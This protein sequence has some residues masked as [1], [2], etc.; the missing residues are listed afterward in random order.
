[1]D[2]FTNNIKL[3]LFPSSLIDNITV[4]KT[5]RPDLPGDWAGAY[6]SIDTKEY[7]DSLSVYVET[8][9]GYNNQTTFKDMVSSQRSSTDW[10]GYDNGFRN[11]DQNN[12]V[13]FNEKPTTYQEFVA[14][15]LGDYLRSIGVT[16]NTPWT[17]EYTK[18]GLVKFGLLGNA[19]IND[20]VAFQKAFDK[21][22]SLEYKGQ[23]F[24]KI[25]ADAVK[26][27]KTFPDTWNTTTRKAPLN[28]SQSFSIGNQTKLFGKPLGYLLGIRYSSAI[29]YDPNSSKNKISASSTDSSGHW[30]NYDF[31]TYQ[32][33]SKET[34]G[35]SGLINLA[36]KYNSNNSTSLMFMP[37]VIGVNSVRDGYYFRPGDDGEENIIKYLFYESRKQ[38][39]YQLK[40]EHYIPGPKI[41]IDFNASYTDGTSNAPDSK[42]VRYQIPR[43]IQYT[44]E[45]RFIVGN[46]GAG[47]YFR[48]LTD[49]IF[50]SRLSA[51]MPIGSDPTL[52]RK[53]KIGGAYQKENRQNDHYFY[54]LSPG[55]G[56][57]QIAAADT[58]AAPYGLDRFNIVTIVDPNNRPNQIRSVQEY[59]NLYDV[60]SNHIFGRSSIKAGYIMIDYSIIPALR[61]SGGLRAEQASMFT[62]CNMFNLNN[63]PANDDRR[64]FN[65]GENIGD[66]IVNPGVLNKVSYLP[67]ANLIV[68]L[69][70]DELAPMNVRLNFSQTVVRPSLQELTDNAFYDYELNAIVRG[71]SNLKM[72]QINNYDLRFEKYF[73][74]GDNIL[75]SIFYKDFRNHI[76]LLNNGS[77]FFWLNNE[78][79]TWLRGVEIEG[80]KAITAY[81]EFKAN[82]T[83]VN[84]LSK[85]TGVY[86][87]SLGHTIIPKQGSNPMFGQAPY[88]INSMLNYYSKKLG[89]IASLNYNV[90]GPRLVFLSDNK[91]IPDVYE[92]PRN[93][94]DFKISKSIGRY[95]SASL[96]FLDILNTP[97]VRAYKEGSGYPLDYDRYKYGTNYVV[98]LSYKF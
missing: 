39:V 3:D 77:S 49:N 54:Q 28:Y 12:F 8:S 70:H 43:L 7:P 65:P 46:T 27:A 15:G 17:D 2:P 41:K 64:Q 91:T 92:L 76:E 63:I 36:Y 61:F 67:S 6:I 44:N 94:L 1:L 24:D 10:L 57:D 19:Q 14:L 37:N 35:W 29:Q 82:I 50:D 72:V 21:Y 13:N 33:V 84:S 69:N 73:A 32:K 68:K 26:S 22:N 89:L 60:P 18:L 93:L 86:K 78:N 88:I 23:A 25:N 83:L 95:F 79:Y 31:S 66:I 80:R 59:Y 81:L 52:V 90:Q 75:L 9:F 4:T 56:S 16:K 38:L 5:A 30:S 87:D 11:H 53:L 97:I 45:P 58:G 48:Y 98:A 42:V 40:S 55:T 71:N 74:S 34:N 85:V 51:E 96:K 47:R 62:D 20:N